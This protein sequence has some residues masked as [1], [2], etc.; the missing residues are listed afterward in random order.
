MFELNLI[1]DKAKARQRRRII[2]LSVVSILFLAGLLSIFVGS[3]WWRETDQLKSIN[4]QVADKEAEIKR[5]GDDLNVR[6]PAAKKRRNALINAYKEDA[7]VRSDRPTFYPILEDLAK[8]HPT[9][10]KFWYNSVLVT[11]NTEGAGPRATSS[12]DPTAGA[13]ALMGTR[14][15]EANGY[16]QIEAS[17]IV[18]ENELVQI[19]KQM[20]GMVRLV[21]EPRFTLAVERETAASAES[22]RYVPFIVR[23]AQ[24]QFQANNP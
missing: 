9:S 24:T 23:A 15:L 1:K 12:D 2:F 20:T 7:L 11:T 17:D 13:K 22:S 16:I 19:A 4:V 21:G 6:E 5:L 14:A 18:T 10:A 3:L 8:Y